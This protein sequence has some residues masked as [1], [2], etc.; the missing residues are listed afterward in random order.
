MNKASIRNNLYEKFC[1]TLINKILFI[2]Y[3][4]RVFYLFHPDKQLIKDAF[5]Y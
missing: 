4:I 1:S 5:R 2:G 3:K